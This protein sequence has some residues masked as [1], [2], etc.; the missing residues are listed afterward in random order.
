MKRVVVRKDLM[1]KSEFS[2]KFSINRP[3]LDKEIEEGKYVVE[4][5]SNKDYVRIPKA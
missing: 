3:Q 4:R 2:K 1:N 5:I